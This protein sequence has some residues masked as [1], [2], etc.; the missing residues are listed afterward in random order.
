VLGTLSVLRSNAL[1]TG[2]T[3]L[4]AVSGTAVGF[5]V[6][7]AIMIGVSDHTVLLWVLLPLAVLVSGAAPSMISFAAGQRVSRW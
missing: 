5:V 6:G 3:A 4:R 7:S 1:G 2:A